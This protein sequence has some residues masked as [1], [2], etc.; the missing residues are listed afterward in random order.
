[1]RP[2]GYGY[3][4]VRSQAGYLWP[5][6]RVTLRTVAGALAPTTLAAL[7][8]RCLAAEAQVECNATNER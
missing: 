3:C 5:Q 7:S 2:G 4:R 1:M 8:Y 6:A